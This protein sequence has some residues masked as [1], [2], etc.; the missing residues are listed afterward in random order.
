LLDFVGE[1]TEV[2]VEAIEKVALGLV[3]CAVANELRLPQRR[4]AALREKRDN[5]S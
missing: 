4:F 3:R 1:P 2:L 5:P